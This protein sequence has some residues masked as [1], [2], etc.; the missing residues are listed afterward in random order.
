MSALILCDAHLLK[1]MSYAIHVCNNVVVNF[2]GT[3]RQRYSKITPKAERML[4]LIIFFFLT[5]RIY[6]PAETQ[7]KRRRH[8]D[9]MCLLGCQFNIYYF[10]LHV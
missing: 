2:Y 9:V 8:F 6:I 10:D 4:K 1:Q 7:R 3:F 5:F